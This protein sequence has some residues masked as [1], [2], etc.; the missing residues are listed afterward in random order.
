MCTK[1]VN[2]VYE[3]MYDK[4]K[5]SVRDQ[6]KCTINAY[7]QTKSQPPTPTQTPLARRPML[8][9]HSSTTPTPPT[10]Y[11]S[12]RPNP[13]TRT[14]PETPPSQEP[15]T[16]PPTCPIPPPPHTTNPHQPTPPHRTQLVKVR[17]AITHSTPLPPDDG[18]RSPPNHTTC[19]PKLN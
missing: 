19:L 5:H 14:P 16:D 2:T 15:A 10:T 6:T 18:N 7:Q 4:C 13:E 12:H 8:P 17:L 9:T 1:N 3:N 11:T